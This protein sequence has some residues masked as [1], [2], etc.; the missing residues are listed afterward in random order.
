MAFIDYLTRN[1][2]SLPEQLKAFSERFVSEALPKGASG[3][4]H[5]VAQRFSLVAGALELAG[6]AGLTGWKKARG[7]IRRTKWVWA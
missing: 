6:I 7:S 2:D 1:Q 5:R 4:V 3:Q